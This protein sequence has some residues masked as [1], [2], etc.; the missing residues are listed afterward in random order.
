MQ[1]GLHMEAHP[2]APAFNE[3]P[4]WQASDTKDLDVFLQS[5]LQGSSG[6]QQV[7]LTASLVP[8][9]LAARCA[10][11]GAGCAGAPPGVADRPPCVPGVP[12]GCS[13]PCASS[14]TQ[15]LPTPLPPAALA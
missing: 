15:T 9:A 14:C 7:D 5:L 12:F 6:E 8:P 1:A 11:S 10:S 13:P 3:D 2:P 4:Y